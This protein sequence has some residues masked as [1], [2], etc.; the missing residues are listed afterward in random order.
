VDNLTEAEFT[1]LYDYVKANFN[2]DK[3]VPQLPQALLDSWTS[4]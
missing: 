2:P 1:T 4:Y 3:P